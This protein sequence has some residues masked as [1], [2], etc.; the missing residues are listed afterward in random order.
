[1]G[2]DAKDRA[3]EFPNTVLEIF[4]GS[5]IIVV[6]LRQRLRPGMVETLRGLLGD[7]FAVITACNPEGRMVSAAENTRRMSRLDAR[8]VELGAVAFRADG[9]SPDGSHRERGWAIPVSREEAIRLGREFEQLAVF[10][11]DSGAFWLVQV[12]GD[13]VGTQLP[14]GG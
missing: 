11:F 6:D 13:T 4:T 12:G 8:V 1:M 14:I 9:R 2:T 10:W 7:R 3:A 5:D